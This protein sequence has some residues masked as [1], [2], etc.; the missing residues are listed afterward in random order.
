MSGA[1]SPRKIAVDSAVIPD[2]RVG[3]K[4]GIHNHRNPTSRAPGLW[5]PGSPLRAAPE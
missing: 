1:R 2:C 5:I 4:S 3:G